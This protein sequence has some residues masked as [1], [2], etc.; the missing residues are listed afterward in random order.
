MIQP[1][2]V[3]ILLTCVI[4]LSA[5][6]LAEEGAL[7]PRVDA[8]LAPYIGTGNFSGAVLLARKGEI[9]LAKGYGMA[10]VEN[11]TPNTADTAFY[12]ASTSRI[13]TSAAIMLLAQQGKLS[14][15]DP[16]SKHFEG[17]PRG[18]EITIHHLLTLSSGMPNINSMSGYALWSQSPQTPR[19]LAEKFRDRPL[20]FRPGERSV[21][22]NSNY[23]VL[24]LLVEKLSGRSYGEFL[25]QSFFKPL[26]MTRT[27]HDDHPDRRVP[28]RARGYVPVGYAEL[29]PDKRAEMIWSVKTGHG[30]IYSTVRDLY[31][32]DRML[33]EGTI[34]NEKSVD[35]LFREHYPTNG[36]GWFVL[37]TEH[38]KRV[39]ISGRSPG[40]GSSWSR[41]V[42]P[43]VTVIVLGN[44][45][46]G[47][48]YHVG[49]ACASM[50]LGEA[51]ALPRLSK[52]PPDPKL[53]DEVVGSYQ[54]GAD[55]YR[56]HAAVGIAESKGHLFNRSAW[57]IPLGGDSFRHRTY[58]STL[59]FLRNERG[60]V[61]R[62]QYDDYV[63]TKK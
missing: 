61:D 35:A 23:V 25:E 49:Q 12:L 40:F 50:L 33:K 26:K 62:L 14:V 18:D 55:F 37:E 45:Y 34:L 44:I 41:D 60:E 28:Y 30:S 36:Y 58:W 46:N 9:L 13:F 3:P 38:G 53:V 51:V 16:L 8:H 32:F 4:A 21:H 11:G 10:E 20:E 52:S 48:P 15:D 19:T 31:K 39:S 54:F 59:T 2:R 56:A 42:E 22:S 24:A 5:S 57:L 29:K 1:N 43:D 6:A 7:E 27:A 63:G 17:W 47:V